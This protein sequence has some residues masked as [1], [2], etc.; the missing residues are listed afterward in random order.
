MHFSSEC[1]WEGSK[2]P[3]PKF[4]LVAILMGYDFDLT[5]KGESFEPF[6]FVS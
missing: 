6:R 2:N 5:E 3:H 1:Q 4:L